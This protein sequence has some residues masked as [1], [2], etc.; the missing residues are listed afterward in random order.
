MPAPL[1][2]ASRL[3]VFLAFL[4][5]GVPA[6]AQAVS[7]A[8]VPAPELMPVSSAVLEGAVVDATGLAVGGATLELRRVMGAGA[9]VVIAQLESDSSGRFRIE[10]LAPGTY[11]VAIGR[12]GFATTTREV[13]LSAGSTT[14][15]EVGLGPAAVAESVTVMATR[16]A[17]VPEELRRMP[18]SIEML[19]AETLATSHVFTVNEAL[20][21]VTG[22]HVRDEEGLGLRPNIG[23]RG[24]NPTRSTKVLLLEDGI[25]LTYAPYGDNASYYHPPVERIESIEVLKGSGQIA[26]G[27]STVGGVI[28][29]VTPVPPQRTSGAATIE[30]GTRDFFNGYGTVGTTRGRLGLLSSYVRR[31]GDGMRDNTHSAINDVTGK[32]VITLTPSQ[33]LTLRGSHYAEDSQITYSGLRLSEYEANPRHNPFLNDEFDGWR[34]GTSATHALVLSSHAV[35]STNVYAS[36]FHRDWWRQSSNSGQ[37]PNDAADPSC[38]GMANLTTTCGNEGR[39]RAYDTVG[40]EPR[41]RVDHTLFG[42][43]QETDLGVRLHA[44]HQDR[45]QE[46]GDTPVS[47]TGRLVESN[48]RDADAWAAFIQHRV[49]LGDL[50]ITPGLRV[51]HVDYTRTNRLGN[52]GAGVSGA[53]SLTQTVPGLGVAFASSDRYTLFG[54]V[55]RGFAPPRVE[56]VVTNTGG[57]VELDPELSW[58]YEAGV[59]SRAAAGLS[60]DGTFFRMDYE[61]QL[62]P[63]SLA[64]GVG[65]TL[66]NGGS[67]LHQ[68]LEVGARV[69]C[70]PLLS[71]RHN[72]YVRTAWTW[73]PIAEFTGVRYS[74]I[75]GFSSVSVSGNRLPYAPAQTLTTTVGYA[76]P[77]GLDLLVEAQY[78]GEQFADDLNTIPS[79]EDGQRGLLPAMTLWNASVNY[80]LRRLPITLFGTVK[81][82]ADVTAIVDRSRGILPS[83]P[84]LVQAGVRVAF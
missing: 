21:K 25:P 27:P 15:V 48:V 81:N 39:L 53:T 28:N 23:I 56:D 49:L 22:V 2:F 47:R 83:A 33:V 67:T 76:Q 84:R 5:L 16:L 14:T 36:W 10:G 51:E 73:L 7:G 31:Q 45:R 41:L 34:T 32:A 38:G 30:G 37:R 62:V 69:D 3:A 17:G 74:N 9:S 13:A 65:A 20:R 24:L 12:S 55:H 52:D 8:A 19:D 72:V 1:L 29:Y 60:L 42:V 46:N 58:N 79:T 6:A 54:G 35:L 57:V 26:F 44:E 40:L 78:V 11:R 80:R 66:T 43:R 63:A 61:N 77:A 64:G 70:S 18:G 59:R 82:L 71:T 4:P 75:P 50:T 68:G